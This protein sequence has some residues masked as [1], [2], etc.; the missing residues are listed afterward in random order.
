M[1]PLVD[2]VALPVLWDKEEILTRLSMILR[3]SEELTA[4]EI[5]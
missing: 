4:Q 3:K 5:I 2:D 1:R